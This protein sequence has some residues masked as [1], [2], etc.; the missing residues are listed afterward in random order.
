MST[1]FNALIRTHHI[2]SRKKVSKLRNAASNHAVYVLL[3][4]GGCPGIMYC[5]GS[6]AGVK[7]WVGT[8]QRLRYKDFQL[9]KKAAEIRQ[10]RKDGDW[11]RL[12]DVDT[13]KEFG[14]RMEQLGVW[15]WWRRGMGYVHED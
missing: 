7:Q 3:R 10:N 2:T 9:V 14:A 12:E 5:E 15:A 4:S 13:V 11:G 6:E 8:V 1:I